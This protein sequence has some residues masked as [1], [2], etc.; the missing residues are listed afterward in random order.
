MTEVEIKVNLA[1]TAPAEDLPRRLV[2]LGFSEQEPLREKDL[3]F[4]APSRDFWETDEA[5]RLRLASSSSGEAVLLTYKGPK[6][7]CRSNTRLEHETAVGSLDTARSILEALGFQPVCTVSKARRT[8]R[9]GAQ[10][11]CLDL[12][13][14]LGAF[15]ELEHMLPDGVCREEAVEGLLALLDALGIPRAALERR[16]Y[17]E[18]LLHRRRGQR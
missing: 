17:L 14:G 7:D 13:D 9:R 18:Q 15:L 10:A 8:F 1:G 16:S 12:V 5:L 4:N 6:V 11:A 3:Y 2:G